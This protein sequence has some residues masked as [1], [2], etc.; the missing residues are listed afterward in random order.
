VSEE[1]NVFTVR[2][3]GEKVRNFRTREEAE[4][5]KA[6]IVDEPALFIEIQEWD[7]GK[8]YPWVKFDDEEEK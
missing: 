7:G 2:C 3:F 1:A 6:A 5:L 4:Q 8:F